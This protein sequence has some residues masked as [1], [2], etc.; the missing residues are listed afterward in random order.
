M[1][2]KGVP[3]HCLT[4]SGPCGALVDAGAGRRRVGPASQR[5]LLVEGSLRCDTRCM[6]HDGS[7]LGAAGPRREVGR[8]RERRLQT[9][10]VGVESIPLHRSLFGLVFVRPIVRIHQLGEEFGQS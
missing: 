5:F 10:V 3:K 6:G 2:M 9:S 4:R 8:D 7:A 1:K